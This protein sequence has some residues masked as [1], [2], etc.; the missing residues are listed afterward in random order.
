MVQ[1]LIS[2]EL[3]IAKGNIQPEAKLREDLGADSLDLTELVMVLEDHFDISIPDSELANI[4]TVQD[5][6]D[7]IGGQAA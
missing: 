6:V 2:E 7:Y 3:I 5:L 4:E 1:G